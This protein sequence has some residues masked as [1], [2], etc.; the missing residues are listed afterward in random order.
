MGPGAVH[1]P[2]VGPGCN[3]Y[4]LLLDESNDI[5]IL[6]ILSVTMIYYSN[7]CGKFVSTYL[8]LMQIEKCDAKALLRYLGYF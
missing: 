4:G 1:H 8:D 3:R 2:L 7:N 5:S 6:E